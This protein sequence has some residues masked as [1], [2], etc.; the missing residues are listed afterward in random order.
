LG[1]TVNTF[2]HFGSQVRKSS[3][4]KFYKFATSDT[5]NV[6]AN[7]CAKT[8]IWLVAMEM[9]FTFFKRNQ[10]NFVVISKTVQ[11]VLVGEEHLLSTTVRVIVLYYFS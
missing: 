4:A 5:A 9:L 8:K 7:V 6:V 10:S 2:K 11:K 1:T 3:N